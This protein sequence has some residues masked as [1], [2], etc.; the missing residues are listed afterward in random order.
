MLSHIYNVI[1]KAACVNNES[2]YN[3]LLEVGADPDAQDSFVS[4]KHWG[5]GI[6][7][8]LLNDFSRGT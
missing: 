7:V 1:K 8:E 5:W 6:N 2:V 3:L 4:N